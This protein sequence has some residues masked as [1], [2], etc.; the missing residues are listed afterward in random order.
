MHRTDGHA[1]VNILPRSS[2]LIPLSASGTQ[3][4]KRKD[5]TAHKKEKKRLAL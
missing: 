5:K 1:F 4:R 2:T 3:V